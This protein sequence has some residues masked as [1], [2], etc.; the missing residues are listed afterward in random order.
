MPL[1]TPGRRRAIVLLL[2]TSVLLLTLD[3]RG[4][5][6]F[7]TARTGFTKLLDPF[8]TAADVVT[9]PVRNAWRGVTNYEEVERENER[10]RD[11][12]DAQ[13]GDQVAAQAAI[14]DYQ[15]LLALND[16]QSLGDYPTVVA[17]VVGESPSNLDQ[18]IEINK[19]SRDGI[20]PGRAV[21]VGAG[22]VGKITTPVLPDRSYVMLL[23][24]SRYAVGVK[25]VPG[26]PDPTTT[27]VAPPPVSG[28][29]LLVPGSEVPPSIET[30]P[31]TTTTVPSSTVP[32]TSPPETTTTSSTTTTLDVTNS[33]DTGQL[34][35]QGA[36][37]LP[38]VDLL[39][40]TPVFG[41]FVPGDI[42]LTSG[43]TDGLAPPDIPIGVV[44]NV[45]NRSSAEGP[46]LEVQQLADLDRLHFV[47]IVLY[48]PESEIEPNDTRAGD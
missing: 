18:V 25:V 34:R 30:T 3:L 5:A 8:E 22:L 6:V 23:T 39:A 20:V 13:R 9:K 35:G 1:Y 17:M 19:G 14:Q 38:Q 29:V 26:A 42:V 32:P 46:L 10:L 37:R 31:V 48:Q 16:L 15:E 2:L 21:T 7:D 24:D 12:L 36:E 40:D 27:T 45:I 43:G 4:N 44:K 47:R 33:R 11:Q 41:R 28:D